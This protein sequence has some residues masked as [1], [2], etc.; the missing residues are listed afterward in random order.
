MDN[1][2]SLPLPELSVVTWELLARGQV[3]YA[4]FVGGQRVK[5]EGFAGVANPLGEPFGKGLQVRVPSLAVALHVYVD[6]GPFV[7]PAADDEVHHELEGVQG[8]ATPTYEQARVVAENVQGEV[9]AGE[10]VGPQPD[11]GVDVQPV[12]YIL[13]DLFG[14][15]D[16]LGGLIPGSNLYSGR[17]AADAEYARST[18]C[19]DDDVDLFSI[20]LEL[21][22]GQVD[23]FLHCLCRHF[24][25]LHGLPSPLSYRR[26]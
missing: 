24:Q 20:C 2:R 9:L 3:D 13:K 22:Q 14:E 4:A 17:L 11:L 15:G 18:L 5:G 25:A 10:A 23:R 16:C 21:F 12:E 6:G 7:E 1:R 19:Y 26:P 8:D